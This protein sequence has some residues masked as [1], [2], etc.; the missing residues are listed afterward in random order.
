MPSSKVRTGISFDAPVL[1]ALNEDAKMLAALQ[2]D[3]SEIVNAILDDHFEGN[4]TTEA[5]WEAVGKMRL[6]RRLQTA[7][8]V[9][10]RIEVET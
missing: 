1:D 4:G 10:R 6:R 8:S 9:E 3:R 7:E 5:V 2:V